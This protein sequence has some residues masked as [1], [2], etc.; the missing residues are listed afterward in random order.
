MKIHLVERSALILLVSF[1]FNEHILQTQSYMVEYALQE[2]NKPCKLN[3]FLRVLI[4]FL[5]FRYC[6]SERQRKQTNYQAIRRSCRERGILYEDPDFPPGPKALYHHRKPNLNPIV[7]MRP[8]V[9]YFVYFSFLKHVE[10]IVI[11]TFCLPHNF[12]WNITSQRF[13]A[14]VEILISTI[15]KMQVVKSI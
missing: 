4:F 12:I 13:P 9:S 14:L 7:W 8:H 1:R 5:I 2:I 6:T 11:I 3:C 15:N 10:R